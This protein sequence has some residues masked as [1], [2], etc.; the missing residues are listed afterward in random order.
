MK[1]KFDFDHD[2]AEVMAREAEEV[3]LKQIEFEQV[4]FK[5]CTT[6]YNLHPHV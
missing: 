6:I 4:L 1:R 3:A 2:K 5:S